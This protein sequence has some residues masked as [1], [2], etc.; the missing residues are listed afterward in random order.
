MTSNSWCIII[1]PVSGNKFYQRK[2][3]QLSKAFSKLNSEFTTQETAFSGHEE[4][5]VEKAIQ[6]GYRKFVSVG[7]DGTLHHVINGV[8][9]H[10]AEGKLLDDFY[11]SQWLV[12]IIGGLR[13][14]LFV[15][16]WKLLGWLIEWPGLGNPCR[17]N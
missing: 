1:N 11:R 3:E 6:L 7:G 17:L 12:I 16:D 4:E 13:S 10:G 8:M 14:I 9:K 15:Q 2:K 5:L